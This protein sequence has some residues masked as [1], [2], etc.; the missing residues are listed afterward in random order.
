MSMDWV[1]RYALRTRRVR[2]SE[3][4]ELLKIAEQPGMIS[5]A[6]GLPSPEAFP[7]Q[8]FEEACHE[9]IAGQANH[10]LQYGQTEGYEPL[11]DWIASNMARYG[12]RA[13]IENVF[14][15]NCIIQVLI[16]RP[17]ARIRWTAHTSVWPTLVGRE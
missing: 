10:A 2:S 17:F 4:R 6:G 16:S 7:L 9:V 8:R 11:R 12:I 1:S 14:I 3:I 13:K 5:F 15:S